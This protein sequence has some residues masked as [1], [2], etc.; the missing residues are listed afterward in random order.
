MVHSCHSLL[1]DLVRSCS[2]SFL[3]KNYNTLL[4]MFVFFREWMRYITHYHLLLLCS[5][6]IIHFFMT[7][8]LLTEQN[9]IE[10]QFTL[11]IRSCLILLDLVQSHSYIKN[12]NSLLSIFWV[13]TKYIVH[14]HLLQ[15]CSGKITHFLHNW[16]S[17][18]RTG[19][20]WTAVHSCHSFLLDFVWS[21]SISFLHKK[22]QCITIHVCI[23]PRMNEIFIHYHLLLLF[24][25]NIIHFFHDWD[26]FDRTEQDW[27]AVHSCHTFLLDLVWSCSISFLHKNYNS[28]LFMFV[29]FREWM[30]YLF[31]TIYYCSVLV[32]SFIFFTT[33]ILLT[34]QNKIEQQFTLVIRSCLILFDLVQSHSYIKNYNSLLFTFVFF[35][36][37][38]SYIIHYHLLLLCSGNIIHFFHDWDSFDITEQDWT[39]VHSCHTFLLDLVWFCSISFLHKNYNSLLFMFVFFREWMRYIIHYHL[40]LLCSGNIVHSFHEWDSFDRMGWDWLVTRCLKSCPVL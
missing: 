1:L 12:Y 15:L 9:K 39:A 18:D 2:I 30:R 17:F 6:N 35:R 20:Y 29:F 21:C 38:M 23:F 25:G 13:W 11:V 31:I 32:I 3:H 16:D 10:Q 4:F 7:G 26:S 33:G 37:W 22:L 40:L 14:Y 5:G 24:S 8:I 27:T 28:L 36:E 34:G 19:Q